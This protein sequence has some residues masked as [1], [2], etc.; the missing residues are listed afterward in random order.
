MLSV[1]TRDAL[2]HALFVRSERGCS[3]T[4]HQVSS[5]CTHEKEDLTTSRFVRVIYSSQIVYNRV[6][7]V[8]E[9]EKK[10]RNFGRSGVGGPAEERS[11]G[12]TVQ[13]KPVQRRPVW[14][15][16][17]P[18]NRRSSKPQTSLRCGRG[19]RGESGLPSLQTGNKFVV[20]V[21]LPLTVSVF[22]FSPF[23]LGL[24]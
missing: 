16:G 23:V 2:V 3:V 10:K 12:G 21:C 4:Q 19:V 5:A 13:R 17:F 18:A 6:V 7:I 1:H 8:S 9:S 11:S 24:S 20:W 15:R 14:S 22:F